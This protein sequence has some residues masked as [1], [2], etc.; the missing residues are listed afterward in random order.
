MNYLVGVTIIITVYNRE[1]F[2]KDAIASVINQRYTNWNLL[3][4][5]DGSTDNSILISKSFCKI[6]TRIKL[7]RAE[8]QGQTKSLL[9]AMELAQNLFN[10]PYFGWLDSDDI[11]H[12]E[13][14]SLTT[15]ILNKNTLTGMVYTNYININQ[16]NK[17]LR[18]GSRCQIPYCKD[19][20]LINFMTF[21]FRLI[22]FDLYN[23]VGGVDP[24]IL[25]VQDYDLCLKLSEVTHIYHLPLI[26]YFYRNHS[27]NISTTQNQSILDYSCKAINNA[28]IRRNLHH[29]IKLTIT[30]NQHFKLTNLH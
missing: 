11:L 17:I 19:K 8:H 3:I 26:L 18:L 15:E 7:I 28:L 22:R 16:Y 14:L 4:W 25:Y 21:H 13:A 12:P 27:A 6:D 1:L 24:N 30:S 20:L 2:I 10:N 23:L 29:S 5:D 9:H